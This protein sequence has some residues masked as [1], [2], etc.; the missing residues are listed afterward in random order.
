MSSGRHLRFR[1][2]L[3]LLL[4]APQPLLEHLLSLAQLAGL[5]RHPFQLLRAALR[6]VLELLTEGDLAL[7]FPV[8]SK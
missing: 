8:A 7:A 1:L 2:R 5:L 4:P 6:G 3:E